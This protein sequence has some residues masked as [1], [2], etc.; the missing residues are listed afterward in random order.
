MANQIP[1]AKSSRRRPVKKQ[2]TGNPVS[3]SQP[4]G[5]AATLQSIDN[6]LKELT[7]IGER[8]AIAIE[9]QSQSSGSVPRLTWSFEEAAASIG[10]DVGTIEYLVRPGVD[11]LLAVPLCGQKGRVIFPEDLN[12]FLTRKHQE[13]MEK[14]S[15]AQQCAD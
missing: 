5:V 1:A 3:D 7:K 11:Q 13:A 15:E 12:T 2:D 10:V 4:P 8:I 9:R 6:S 14:R